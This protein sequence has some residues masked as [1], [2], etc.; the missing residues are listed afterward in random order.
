MKGMRHVSQHPDAYES[1][2]I[3]APRPA[4]GQPGVKPQRVA[5]RTAAWP[6]PPGK[7]GQG[8]NGTV[9]APRIKTYVKSSY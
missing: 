6:G 4:P 1:E 9:K 5:E 2:D 7:T 3:G 8:M